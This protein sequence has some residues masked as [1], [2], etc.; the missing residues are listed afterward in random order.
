M[1]VSE[2]FGGFL[3]AEDIPEGSD[4][5]VTIE[6]VREPGPDDKG[7]DGKRMDKPIVRLAKVKKEWVLNKT[8]AKLIR[9]QHGNETSDW[10]GKKISIY[11]TTCPAFGDPQTPCIRVRGERL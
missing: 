10:H 6:S 9:R 11:R 3:E 7:K 5:T 8:N 4:I 1:K 2:V